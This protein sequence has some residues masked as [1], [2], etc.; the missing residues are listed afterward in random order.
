M[1]IEGFERIAALDEVT[2]A[3]PKR[4]MVGEREIVLFRV[5]DEIFAVENLCP[6]QQF[7]VFHQGVLDGYII[8]CP[9]HAWSFDIR[10]GRAVTGSGRI[11]TFELCVVGNEVL[12]K[13]SVDEQKFSNF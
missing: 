2:P 11:K 10:S 1:K 13:N 3:R 5:E 6:H 8:T 4:V 12:I 9:M 7:S